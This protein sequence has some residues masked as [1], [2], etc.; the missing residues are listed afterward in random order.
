MWKKATLVGLLL[1]LIGG[2]L[3]FRDLLRPES[4]EQVRQLVDTYAAGASEHQRQMFDDSL[5]AALSLE[6]LAE[7]VRQLGGEPESQLQAT[8]DRHWT[9][10]ARRAEL[11]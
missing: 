8:S 4:D 2:W 9:W 11:A 3:F 5:R 7:L 6:E 10:V 1:L